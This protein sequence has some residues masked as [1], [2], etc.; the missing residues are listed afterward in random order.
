M[1]KVSASPPNIPKKFVEAAGK[2]SCVACDR[3]SSQSSPD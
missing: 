1:L 3:T 2:G